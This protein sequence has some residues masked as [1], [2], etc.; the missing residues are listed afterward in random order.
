[1]KKISRENITLRVYEEIKKDLMTGFFKPGERLSIRGLAKQLGTSSTPVREAVVRLV[2]YGALKMKPSRS[3][4][5]PI[6][7]RDQY[8][9]N[10]NLRTVIEGLA[11]RTATQKINKIQINKMKNIN[12]QL[13]VAMEEKRYDKILEF[14]HMFHIELCKAS[15]LPTLLII[16][17]ILWLQIGP[18]LNYMFPRSPD[19]TKNSWSIYHPQI[20]K[21]LENRDSDKAVKALEDDLVRGGQPILNY[22]DQKKVRQ[23]DII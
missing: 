10:R 4:T 2:S 12:S 3:I 5:V 17:E 16:A 1:L 9:E 21:A 15:G 13:N 7:S 19:L 22:F 11:L 8:I 14:N 18:L 23:R 6:L 20:V